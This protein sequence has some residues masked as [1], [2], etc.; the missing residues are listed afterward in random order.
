[1]VFGLPVSGYYYFYLEAQ[2]GTVTV[3]V[4]STLLYTL[5]NTTYSSYIFLM[6]DT[7]IHLTQSGLQHAITV[8]LVA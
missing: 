5:T 2:N 4:G 6:K 1:M 3:Y 7:E 8:S